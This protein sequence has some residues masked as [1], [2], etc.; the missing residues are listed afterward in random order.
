MAYYRYQSSNP[1][2]VPSVLWWLDMGT[3]H[4]AGLQWGPGDIFGFRGI[5]EAA[6]DAGPQGLQTL[7]YFDVSDIRWFRLMNLATL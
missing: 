7:S 6:Q 4:D 3:A 1:L 5:V 2:K